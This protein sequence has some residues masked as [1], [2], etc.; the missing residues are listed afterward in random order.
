MKYG[1]YEVTPA[2]WGDSYRY[3]EGYDNR[4]D[5]EILLKCLES[6][7]NLFNTYKIIEWEE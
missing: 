3:V 6:I 7:N 1:V 4:K 5:A 2:P